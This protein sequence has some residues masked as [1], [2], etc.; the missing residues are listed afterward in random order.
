M[1]ID[2]DF[3]PSESTYVSNVSLGCIVKKITIKLDVGK[4]FS[5][6]HPI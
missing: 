6:H 2:E 3:F 5:T 4:K 1:Q